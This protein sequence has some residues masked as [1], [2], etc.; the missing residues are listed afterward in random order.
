MRRLFLVLVF[1]VGCTPCNLPPQSNCAPLGQR[2]NNNQPEV[3]SQ[4]RRWHPV[5]DVPCVH[6]CEITGDG[7]A[8][9]SP[10]GAL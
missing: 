3:C 8:I 1:A 10:A 2:C 9:C 6:G 5:G 4:T 7:F